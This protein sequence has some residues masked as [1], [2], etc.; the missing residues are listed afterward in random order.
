[1]TEEKTG[2]PFGQ[3]ILVGHHSERRHRNVIKRANAAW[4]RAVEDGKMADHHRSAG[5]GL[6]AALERSI[7]S[8]DPDAIE[9]LEEKL[10]H[11]EAKR[12]AIAAVNKAWRKAKKPA[13]HDDGGWRVVAAELGLTL[14]Q[15]EPARRNQRVCWSKS[16]YAPYVLSN[17]GGNI[18]RVRKRIQDVKWRQEQQAKVEAA[19]GMLIERRPDVQR[20]G[21]CYSAIVD[22]RCR[23]PAGYNNPMSRPAV[24]EPGLCTV[25]FEDFPGR[26]IVTDLKAA[27][28]V[29]SGGAWHGTTAKLPASVLAEEARSAPDT[30]PQEPHPIIQAIA[31]AS[32]SLAQDPAACEGCGL[33]PE[34]CT[35]EEPG[36]LPPPEGHDYQD[37]KAGV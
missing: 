16:P 8:D 9:A 32:E 37:W 13:A 10:Q 12:D 1:M 5:A 14:D 4:D 19:G 33:A 6:A 3:P 15:L 22:G 27:G 11:L 18:S 35:C 20:C 17:L 23:C 30:C 2:I 24:T 21:S 31:E 26:Q 7:F 36:P 34:H 25:R 29:W 28:F